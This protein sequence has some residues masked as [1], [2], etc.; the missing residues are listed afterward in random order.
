MNFRFSLSRYALLATGVVTLGLLSGQTNADQAQPGEISFALHTLKETNVEGPDVERTYF[1]I[2][3]KRIVIGQPKGC[4][5]KIENANLILILTDAGLDGEIHVSRSAFT[6]E[7]DLVANALQYRDAAVKSIPKGASEIVP[8][9][10][11]LNFYPYNGWKSIGLKSTYSLYGRSMTRTV[12]YVNL[13][14]GAQV[15]VTMLAANKD[16]EKVEK[17]AQQFMSSWWVKD[18]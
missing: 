6:P 2:G 1:T 5:F 17:L 11:I 3:K 18:S 7:L 15:V 16:T 4:R 8:Q 13:E 14:V 9:P 12:T 10:P